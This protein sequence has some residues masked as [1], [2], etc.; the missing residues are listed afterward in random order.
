LIL[1]LIA[2]VMAFTSVERLLHPLV[3]IFNEAIA[4]AVIGLVVNLACITVLNRGSASHDH[5]RHEDLNFRSAYLHVI[6]DSLTSVFA[7]IALLGAKYYSLNWLD[8]AM[9]LVGAFLIARWAVL[10][11]KRRIPLVFD[12]WF[13]HITSGF[14]ICY[15]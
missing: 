10:L 15:H 14:L 11:L 1:G 4:V 3:I 5:H 6:A 8:P 9:G 13:G 12:Q 2:V 7:I